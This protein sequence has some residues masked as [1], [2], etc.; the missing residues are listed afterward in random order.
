[1]IDFRTISTRTAYKE[2]LA[3]YE[4]LSDAEKEII[5]QEMAEFLESIRESEV[6]QPRNKAPE[7]LRRPRRSRR[8]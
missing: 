8:S 6:I 4:N 3:A 2:Y 1:M 5:C 7:P